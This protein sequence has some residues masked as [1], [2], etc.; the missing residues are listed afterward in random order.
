MTIFKSEPKAFK[1]GGDKTAAL[2]LEGKCNCGFR[3][4][5]EDKGYKVIMIPEC[6]NGL[7]FYL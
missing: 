4:L 2:C 3:V 7:S 6:G 5:K 1:A